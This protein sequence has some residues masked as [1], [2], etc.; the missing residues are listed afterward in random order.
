MKKKGLELKDLTVQELQD[1][2]QDERGALTKLR[3]NHTVSPIENPMQLRSK[4]K[5][6]ARI[7]TELRNRE[8]ANTAGK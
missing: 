6:V 8:L 2:L 3:F 4:R 1:K 7:L 5:E